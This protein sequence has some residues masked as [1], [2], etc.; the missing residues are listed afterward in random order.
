MRTLHNNFHKKEQEFL[1]LEDDLRDQVRVRVF[2]QL[3]LKQTSFQPAPVEWAR[4]APT[5]NDTVYEQTVIQ[6]YVSDGN[7]FA[8]VV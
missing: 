3:G 8:Y 4:C 7:A 1:D 5:E 2:E 6:G